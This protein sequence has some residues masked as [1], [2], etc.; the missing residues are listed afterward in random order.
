MD[1][2]YTVAPA[3]IGACG[4]TPLRGDLGIA[5]AELLT[6]GDSAQSI[7]HARMETTGP[8]RMPPLGTTLV[9]GPALAAIAG[10]IDGMQSCP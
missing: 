4:V 9:H 6:P 8:H 2:R 7:I 5:G 3:A 1:F 10:W